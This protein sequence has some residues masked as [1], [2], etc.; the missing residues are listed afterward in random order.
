MRYLTVAAV[1]LIA[2]SNPAFAAKITSLPGGVAQ[3][4]PA[5]SAGNNNLDGSIT[6]RFGVDNNITASYSGGRHQWGWTGASY[7]GSLRYVP[8]GSPTFGGADFVDG[9]LTL[10]FDDPV[11]ALL[12]TPLWGVRGVSV[13][14]VFDTNGA[15]LDQLLLGA[16]GD[17]VAFGQ[18]YG[19]SFDANRIGRFE[20]QGTMVGVGM[21]DLSTTFAVVS[22]VPEP[23]SW[24][25]MIIGFGLFGG[26][27]RHRRARLAM[28]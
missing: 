3:A 14:R 7:Y 20:L 21:R 11:N 26:S 27:L 16:E 17:K 8:G 10:T 19:F 22:S 2:I 9:L 24:A 12:L 6:H 28:S 25:M 18:Q 15:L 5:L 13:M 1:A 23:A 4:I